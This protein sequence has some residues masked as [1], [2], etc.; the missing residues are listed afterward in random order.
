D[1]GGNPFMEYQVPLAVLEL[2]QGLGRLLRRESD[3]GILAV[4]DPRLVSRRYGKIFLRSLPPYSRAR[5][6]EEAR[7][8]FERPA[9]G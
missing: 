9:E 5:T 3:R 8:F 7:E 4:M 2:K 1:S 6:I